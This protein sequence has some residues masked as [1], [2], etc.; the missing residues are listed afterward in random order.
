M[1][2]ALRPLRLPA[3]PSLGV[4]YLVNELGNW[5]GEIALAL[6]VFDRTGEPMAVA[7]LFCGMHFAPA[8]IG[9]PV[10]ARLERYPARVTLP[11]LY[12]VEAAAF[13]ALALLSSQFSLLAVLALATL[14]G[15]VAS[16]ARAL[17]RASAAAVLAPAGQLR[18]GNAL[19]NVAFTVGAAGGPAMAG[20]VVAGAGFE[21]ALLADAVS[22]LAV[23]ALLGATRSL[24]AP[25][26]DDAEDGWSRR[27]RRGLAYVRER[28]ALR[29]LLGA[30]A[31]AFVFF[32]LVIPVEVVFAKQTLGT[33]DAGYG[34]L[35]AS[36]G[37]GMVAGSLMF[38]GLR[39][40]SLR[41]LLLASTLAIGLAYLGIG[42]APTLLVA[43]AAS[44]VG[45]LGNGIQ[46]IALVTA[47]QELTRATYQARVLALLEAIASAM[48]GVGFL[49]GGAI[50]AIFTP[51]ISFAVAGAGVLAVALAAVLGLRRVGWVAELEQGEPESGGPGAPATS[52]AGEDPPRTVLTGS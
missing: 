52:V 35:L 23:A 29:R 49:L 42:A 6:L 46:W 47:V 22:F 3:F 4:A 25:Q 38:A 26:T 48:P 18:E 21:T 19:L 7:A 31:A 28:P 20:L 44:A 9:P 1:P 34:V 32:A 36:W 10:V 13:A 14:D 41:A 17:T 8:L 40:V 24:R 5:L 16:A 37:A 45:G 27:L 11:A 51:R 43:C 12:A 30:Q 39:R 50:A 33:G 2:A 15:S